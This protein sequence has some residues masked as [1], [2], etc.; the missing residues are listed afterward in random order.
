M[1][2]VTGAAGLIGGAV[3]QELAASGCT[4]VGLVH[5]NLA[6]IGNDRRPVPLSVFGTKVP[7]RGTVAPLRGDIRR[8]LLGLD[9][10]ALAWLQRHVEVVVHCAALV[11]FEADAA[12]LDAVNVQ[13]TLN[14]AMLFPAAR[15]IHV[16]TA[17][18]CG[19][20]DGPVPETACDP[21]GAF[22]NGYE[23]SKATAEFRLRAL[24]PDACILRPSIVVGEQR[25]GRIRDFDTIY[26]AFKFIAE[27]RIDHVPVSSSATLNFVPIDH[28]VDSTCDLV[29]CMNSGTDWSGKIMHLAAQEAVPAARFLGL[30]GRVPGLTAPKITAPSE[31]PATD[32]GLSERLIGPYWGYF[33]RNPQFET[34]QAAR[35]LGRDAP[36]MGDA[37]L[38]RQIEFCVEAGFIRPSAKARARQLR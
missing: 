14:V 13:G 18:V 22:G 5:D 11:R 25:T 31:E 29:S 19:L 17:Y 16:S 36:H 37:E 20:L 38:L 7:E 23:Q 24:R 35:L 4:V 8:E 2:L 27:G 3:V 26:R 9:P 6:I 30:L 15:F 1:I 32:P 33:R 34:E 12:A 10:A 21:S 28:V